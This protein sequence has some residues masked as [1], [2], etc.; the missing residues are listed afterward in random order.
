MS[1]WTNH[2]TYCNDL[3]GGNMNGPVLLWRGYKVDG[4]EFFISKNNQRILDPD[5]KEPFKPGV[6]ELFIEIL[7]GNGRIIYPET[8]GKTPDNFRKQISI[9]KRGL[10]EDW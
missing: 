6:V 4:R 10:G 1:P 5:T 3:L 9:L 8:L 7:I 2:K